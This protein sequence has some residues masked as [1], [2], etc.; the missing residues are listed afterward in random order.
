M[1]EITDEYLYEC[2]YQ[3]YKTSRQVT[4]EII[5]VLVSHTITLNDFSLIM[6]AIEEEVKFFTMV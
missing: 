6:K 2:N 1:K 5:K 3:D 4:D